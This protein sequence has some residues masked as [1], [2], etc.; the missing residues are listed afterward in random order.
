MKRCVAFATVLL[1]A[2][3]GACQTPDEMAAGPLRS[4]AP[5]AVVTPNVEALPDLIVDARQTDKSWTIRD[6]QP[7]P[8]SV[9]EGGLTD[10]VHRLM[11]FTVNT[12]NV[13]TADV[14]VGNPLDHVA[15]NDGLFEFASCH[16][17]FH[18]RNYATYELV[19]PAGTVVRAAKRGFCMIDVVRFHGGPKPGKRTY[20][21]CGTQ[22]TR[23][24]QGISTGWADSYSRVLDGQFFVLDDV[25]AGAYTIRITVNPP[26]TCGAGDAAR[27][28]DA[29][30]FCHMFAESD[31]GNNVGEALVSVPPPS[32]HGATGP[33]TTNGLTDDELAAIRTKTNS[34]L[35]DHE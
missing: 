3:M 11:R 25:P 26:F 22:T 31:Y 14:V 28:R 32:S 5:Q 21:L 19:S 6:E 24:N 20:A 8:C 29:A 1:L 12:P 17:H 16:N 23:G 9:I 13:G 30:G 15:A 35:H 4:T 33:G 18:F 2:V 7:S 34:E 27:P 10:A